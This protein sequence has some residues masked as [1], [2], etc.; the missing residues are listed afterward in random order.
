[1]EDIMQ[2]SGLDTKLYK[3]IEDDI[4]RQLL[5]ET[6]SLSF[7]RMV[8]AVIEEHL[9]QLVALRE[10]TEQ[11]LNFM[12]FPTRDDIADVAKKVIKNEERLD[13]LDDNLYQTMVELKNSRKQMAKLA[14]K[15]AEISAEL[16][17]DKEI[18][19]G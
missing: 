11:W 8:G 13:N 15:M 2:S 12:D 19:N 4:N 9:N 16:N 5:S 3:E 14:W 6:N 17:T 1:M 10:L 7:I 18:G